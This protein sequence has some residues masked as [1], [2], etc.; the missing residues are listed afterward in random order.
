MAVHGGFH[1][2][3]LLFSCSLLTG[4]VRVVRGVRA[5]GGFAALA[6]S[7]EVER[8]CTATVVQ[9]AC[10]AMGTVGLPF[11]D[12]FKPRASL[13]RLASTMALK[14][15]EAQELLNA[16]GLEVNKEGTFTCKALCHAA[17]AAI[18]SVLGMSIPPAAG[19]ACVDASCK[20]PTVDVSEV[21]LQNESLGSLPHEKDDVETLAQPPES[22]PSY[23]GDAKTML[24]VALNVLFGV[25]PAPEQA[26]DQESSFLQLSE[27]PK[28]GPKILA[29]RYED[30]KRFALKASAWVATA[31]KK[32]EP[33][34][35]MVKKWFRMDKAS[36]EDIDAQ[37]AEA[38]SH[39][40][41]MQVAL[42]KL[43]LKKGQP[44][45]SGGTCITGEEGTLAYVVTNGGCTVQSG[46][47][48]GEKSGPY[49]VVNIC[50]HF[51][52]FSNDIMVGT[53]VHESSHH[54]G[55]KDYAY[56]E[57]D[58]LKLSSKK[59]R[60]NADTYHLLVASLAN[61][62]G[63]VMS[64]P[65]EER[66]RELKAELNDLV[67]LASL[68]EAMRSMLD[69]VA[70]GKERERQGLSSFAGQSLHMRFLGNPGTGKTV[71]ARI[72]GELL[73][74]MGAITPKEGQETDGFVFREASRADLVAE[75]KGQTAPKVQKLVQESLGG[76]LFIDEA[77]ALVQGPKDT[78]GV[79][80]VD[81]LIKEMEDNRKHIVVILA[82][83]DKEME[84]FFNSNPGFKS[85]VPFS[86]KFDDYTCRELVSIGQLQLKSKGLVLS[87]A[88][89]CSK[90]SSCWWLRRS[91][92]LSTKCCDA[93]D[94]S[95]CHGKEDRS[96]GNGRT[97][98][99]ILESSFR[100][101][102][103][104]VLKKH[105]PDNLQRIVNGI[106]AS[107]PGEPEC[108]AAAS[109]SVTFGGYTGPDVRCSFKLLESSDLLSTS[110]EM[111]NL[112]LGPCKITVEQDQVSI[113]AAGDA[114]VSLAEKISEI[115]DARAKGG[116]ALDSACATVKAFVPKKGSLV[117]RS[118]EE[119]EGTLGSSGAEE[120]AERLPVEQVEE[121][122]KKN[123]YIKMSTRGFCRSR[124]YQPL[125]Y[126]EQHATL[127]E[128]KQTCDLL[129]ACTGIAYQKGSRCMIYE[130][131]APVY[132][133]GRSSVQCYIKGEAED[134]E[135]SNGWY[136]SIASPWRKPSTPQ[137]PGATRTPS[138]DDAAQ[139]VEETRVPGT[140][141]KVA[142]L[143]EKLN[144]LVGLTRVKAGMGELHAMVAFDHWRK[145]L[146]P[147]AKTLM[148]QSFHMQ[149]LG[150]PGTGK[151]V[152]ARI[153]GELLV[154]MGVIQAKEGSADNKK[155][156]FEEVSRADLVAEY[157]GQ[158][159]PKVLAAVEGA[160]GGVLFVDEAYSLKKE[161]KDS[162]GQEAVDTLIKEIEDKRD[163]VIAIFAG[164]E[165][166]METFFDANPGFKSRVP[167]KFYFDDY[168][169][170]ELRTMADIFLKSKEFHA[171]TSADVWL[172]RTIGFTTGCCENHDCE[173]QR[174]NGNGRTVRNILEASYRNF[175]ERVVPTVY[176]NQ[177][178]APV[179][180]R[181]EMF[182]QK[183]VSE[184][185]S[186]EI[187]FATSWK[188]HLEADF[189]PA[190]VCANKASGSGRTWAALCR[191]VSVQLTEVDGEDVALVAASRALD[192]LLLS[193]RDTKVNVNA[194]ALLARRAFRVLDEAQWE[195]IEGTIKEQDCK[196]VYDKLSNLSGL[197]AAPHYDTLS[198]MEDSADLK[199]VLEKLQRLVGLQNVKDTM[200]KLYGLVKLS[201][202][203]ES[204]GMSRLSGQSFH[205]R[206]L[207]NPGTGKTVV[208]RI[209]GE[210]LVKMGVVDLPSE[211]RKELEQ[212]EREKAKEEGRELE[213]GQPVELPLIFKEVS[214]ADLVA[215]HTGQ[216]APKVEKAVGNATGGVL[217][218][219]EAYAIVRDGG[220]TFGQEA[221]DTLIKEMEDKRENVVVILAGYEQ[222]M[223]DFFD[224]NPG[225]KSR[226]PLTFRFEDYTCVELSKISEMTLGSLGISLASGAGTAPLNKLIGFSTGCCDDVS[227]PDCHPS[228]E[229]G[230]GRTV[231][232]LAEALSRA[233][234]SRVMR[235][236]YELKS[237]IGKEELT[238]LTSADVE[239]V[240][241]DQAQMRLETPCGRDGLLEQL[242]GA[243][244]QDGGVTAWFQEYKL[245]DP[246]KRLHTLV[247]ETARIAAAAGTFRSKKLHGYQ[248]MCDKA[249]DDTVQALSTK[250]LTIC[251]DSSGGKSGKLTE[252]STQV[253][254]STKLSLPELQ[255][256][257]AAIESTT[258][259]AHRLRS[260][261][262]GDLPAKMR[263][264]RP[265]DAA[266]WRSIKGMLG[267][268][269]VV[270][271]VQ[272]VGQLGKVLKD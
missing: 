128:C 244:T 118:E 29:S 155:M 101:M 70:F 231:R 218:I 58:C 160:L 163:R 129:A 185:P 67:G 123:T 78:F 259:E 116:A 183:R 16:V 242:R 140:N 239:E 200:G 52:Q 240:A 157:K 204:L 82:G 76:V 219:D 156:V 134:P 168:S 69:L 266:C 180:S 191:D 216:T 270:P 8:L 121:G 253:D 232:N 14:V 49:Y 263:S 246:V 171:S 80:A 264:L 41:R 51:W 267:K 206:F 98:R 77:Y 181:G 23:P 65:S 60:A 1:R 15:E 132:S 63:T 95:A 141:A 258:M 257:L 13:E 207:G 40:T 31:L 214:R 221:V 169:C 198:L 18:P 151:T 17:V 247:R 99:N 135:L 195:D 236:H 53:L 68:K 7:E 103:L 167:F 225:F 120:A 245:S 119:A 228:R 35:A 194:L 94:R 86:F 42:S 125:P 252:L 106:Q 5:S 83:Y 172:K 212:Q 109:E 4:A 90:G 24:R 201:M 114:W 96:N 111:L 233:M 197:P 62:K 196:G 182:A 238:T 209:V 146:L 161:G 220:D 89:D 73:M 100:A 124:R 91:A 224:S 226:V 87:N 211:R 227:S 38:R 133:G 187:K 145:L 44:K 174:D 170:S 130:G 127:K 26:V 97:M 144:N 131:K 205:M 210:M 39:L 61:A 81:T 75:Y 104:R 139:V 122:L 137:V 158:T 254:T 64:G 2:P 85:R 72:V 148:G 265:H 142:A 260:L 54:F 110:T 20:Q 237:E 251:G 154:E 241:E 45:S 256:F 84:D 108:N 272:A 19:R 33:R 46:R 208:A 102:A 6:P 36:A 184:R 28:F 43:Y 165:K 235:D 229:N 177:A 92:L 186:Y 199:P 48:C 66:V 57:K 50:E 149:F 47:D 215:S 115:T 112:N 166:E 261:I 268:R 55:T 9:A 27:D 153:V 243:L 203:R 59:A 10:E 162:F 271:L 138:K 113:L 79:E 71:V 11:Q 192:M 190:A 152:V 164:Y 262:S 176:R 56:G 88:E 143:M 230:N 22:E 189:G 255:R 32:L 74:A 93:A 25:F 173:A 12:A 188:R 37:V 202:W 193:C 175:A 150:N 21:V 30:Y 217:F 249:I 3:L 223:D 147:E 159:A 269:M 126:E 222:E 248:E 179:L 117:Q 105:Q 178:L 34:K 250:A 107:S 136:G 213:R 234:A